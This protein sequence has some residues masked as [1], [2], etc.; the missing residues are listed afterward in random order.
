MFLYINLCINAQF[1]VI[2]ICKSM[3]FYVISS[4]FIHIFVFRNLKNV[5]WISLLN[6]GFDEI[7]NNKEQIPVD[8]LCN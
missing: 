3:Y 6:F 8:G 4:I 7:V 2:L 1:Y 5:E